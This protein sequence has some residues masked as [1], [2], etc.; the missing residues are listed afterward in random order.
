M[1]VCAFVCACVR[2]ARCICTTQ[3]IVCVYSIITVLL[4]YIYTHLHLLL[5]H[6]LTRPYSTR[7]L[8]YRW[9]LSGESSSV[10]A[11]GA[12]RVRLFVCVLYYM[13][14]SRPQYI[15]IIIYNNTTISCAPYTHCR[16]VYDII[17]VVTTIIPTLGATQ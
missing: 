8:S 17:V 1:C 9:H 6:S 14:N 12:L 5:A 13:Y 7:A 16:V 10:S 15:I 3:R 4:L 2:R 11:F